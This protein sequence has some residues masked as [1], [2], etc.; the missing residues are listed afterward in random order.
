[1]WFSIPIFFLNYKDCIFFF[2]MFTA[3]LGDMAVQ[4]SNWIHTRANL[5]QQ[6]N[7][8]KF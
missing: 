8:N 7:A 5:H 4:K 6:L 3:V 1:M 2:V